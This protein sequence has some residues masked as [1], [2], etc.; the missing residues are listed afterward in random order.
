ME[1]EI[2]QPCDQR[3]GVTRQAGDA[4][5]GGGEETGRRS[6]RVMTRQEGDADIRRRDKSGRRPKGRGEAQA[7]DVDR[8]WCKKVVR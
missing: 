3:E 5:S 7:G 2:R 8:G 1:G 6:R 4:D